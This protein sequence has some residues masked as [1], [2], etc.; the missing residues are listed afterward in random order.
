MRP[1]MQAVSSPIKTV[2]SLLVIGDYSLKI[3]DDDLTRGENTGGG[4]K[5]HQ[6][7]GS[8]LGSD[9]AMYVGAEESLI[10]RKLGFLNF[11]AAAGLPP[12]DVVL[13]YLAAA[14]DPFEPVSRRAD[15]LLKKR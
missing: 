1:P 4:Y 5:Q 15:E 14:T 9:V 10:N 3:K 11:T 2:S 7:R 12:S 6:A 13:H 8:N